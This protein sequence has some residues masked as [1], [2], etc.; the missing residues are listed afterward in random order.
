MSINNKN[1]F[2]RRLRINIHLIF[3][4]LKIPN[5]HFLDLLAIVV[6]VVSAVVAFLFL[7]SIELIRWGV[8]QLHYLVNESLFFIIIPTLGGLACGLVTF[9]FSPNAKGQGI[10]FVIY[11]VLVRSG[12]IELRHCISRMFATIFTLGTM[13]SAGT[14][15]PVVYFGSAVGSGFGQSLKLSP[16]NMK[17]MVGCGSAAGIAATFQAPIGG[18]LFALE[19]IL[20]SFSPTIFSPIIIASVVSAVTFKTIAGDHNNYLADLV[21]EQQALEVFGFV[22]VGAICGLVAVGFIKLFSKFNSWFNS[23]DI[24]PVY[25]PALGGFLTGCILLRLPQ[26]EGN[27]YEMVVQLVRGDEIIWQALLI[28]LLLKILATCFTLSSGGVG[29]IFAPSLVFGAIIGAVTHMSLSTFFSQISSVGIYVMVGMAAFVSGTT[30]GP[31]AAILIFVRNDGNYTV[32]LP[33]LAGCVTSIV[34]ARSIS[35]LSAYSVPLKNLG[36]HLRDGHDLD[37][38]KT[39]KVKDLMETEILSVRH[40]QKVRDVLS[41]IHNSPHDHVLVKSEEGEIEGVISYYHLTPFLLKQTDGLDKTARETMHI[42]TNYVYAKDAVIVAYDLFPHE[43]NKL[44]VSTGR[45]GLLHRNS[46]QG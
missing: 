14:E 34:V 26:I 46:F 13:G 33:L 5:S 30:H 6:G 15:G 2:F 16:H 24:H 43:G 29:G 32:I 9:L 11:A 27:S 1:S 10:P 42:T 41:I 22:I 12:L 19:A 3:R 18:V 40:N 20:H 39:Y 36:I 21:Y 38:L 31:F 7:E 35:E 17:I 45:S 44:S 4:R 28:F 25:K 23:I 37:V 8:G